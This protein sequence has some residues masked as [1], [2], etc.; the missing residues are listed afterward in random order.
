MNTRQLGARTLLVVLANLVV[1]DVA[2]RFFLPGLV[3]EAHIRALKQDPGGLLVSA[4]QVARAPGPKVVFLGDS[5]MYGS[6]VSDESLTIPGFY[7]R[8]L[9][10]GV[11][12]YNLGMRGYGP[13]EV[14]YLAD[15]LAGSGVDLVIYNLSLGWFDPHGSAPVPD[16]DHL[17]PL[18]GRPGSVVWDRVQRLPVLERAKLAV[19][20]NW[21]LL[22]HRHL[23][24]QL[25]LSSV[26]LADPFKSGGFELLLPWYQRQFDARVMP[27]FGRPV[28]ESENPVLR[29]LEMAVERL[30]RSG[31][32]VFVYVSPQNRAMYQHYTGWDQDAV[33]RSLL[34]VAN[35][36]AAAGGVFADYLELVEAEWFSDTIHLLAEGHRQVAARLLADTGHLLP[37]GVP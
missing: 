10:P 16:V 24:R 4:A 29:E 17:L 28:L 19:R 5:Q 25:L 30:T 26:G 35:S 14:L 33:E 34:V 21:M 11:Q 15:V 20:Q 12:V 2:L 13:R 36:V 32:S 37:Q 9:G 8:A 7:S 1:I 18:W 6:A 27:V 31:T 22:A 3:H 23:L